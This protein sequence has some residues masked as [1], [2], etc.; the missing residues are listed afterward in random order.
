MDVIE[1]DEG[2]GGDYSLCGMGRGGMGMCLFLIF[3]SNEEVLWER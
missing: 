2:P 1:R 3:V